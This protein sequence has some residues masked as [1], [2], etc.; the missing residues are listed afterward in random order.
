MFWFLGG[1]KLQ[2]TGSK[3]EEMKSTESVKTTPTATV[4]TQEVKPD[5]AAEPVTPT[6]LAALQSDVQPV[7]HDYVEEVLIW[8]F[9]CF[10]SC[11]GEKLF[12]TKQNIEPEKACLCAYLSVLCAFVLSLVRHYSCW[13][14]E[15]YRIRIWCQFFVFCRF[16]ITDFNSVCS[17][18]GLKLP[19]L[20]NGR[21]LFISKHNGVSDRTERSSLSYFS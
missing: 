20:L 19:I 13:W 4:Q 5:T 1:N 18:S 10:F 16:A 17:C 11:F 7:G 15:V 21:T 14:G 3:L 6:T 8:Q 2:T 9:W 12:R